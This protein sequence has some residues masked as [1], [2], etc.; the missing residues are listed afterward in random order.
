MGLPEGKRVCVIGAGIAGVS[1]AIR[2]KEKGYHVT[3]YEK[4][5]RI[6]GKCYTRELVVDG[7]HLTFEMGAA[8]VAI[9]YR[10]LLR[11][12]RMLKEET[13]TAMPYK[14]LQASGEIGSFRQRYWPKGKKLALLSQFIRCAFH[15]HRFYRK[16]VTKTGYKSNI[17]QEYLVPFWEYCQKHRMEDLVAWFELPLNAWGYGAPKTIPVWYVFGEIDFLGLFGLLITVTF[18]ESKFIKGLKNG[19][20]NLVEKLAVHEALN[21]ETSTDVL[22][23][24][25]QAG[26]VTIKT[27]KGEQQFDRLV[28]SS[29]KIGKLLSNPSVEESAFLRD[30]A[31]VPFATSL[32]TLNKPVAAKLLVVQNLRKINAVKIIVAPDKDSPLAVCYANIDEQKTE[33]EVSELFTRELGSLGYGPIEIHETCVWKDYFPHFSTYEGYKSLLAAQGKNRT[34]YVGV[35]NKFEFIEATVDSS[36]NLIDENFTGP[37]PSRW[38]FLSILRNAFFMLK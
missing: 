25:R 27:Q 14:V 24:D 6:G 9:N 38:E 18:G 28:I 26:G 4:R 37:T 5:D 35:I 17:P 23:I 7:K 11:Y 10:N 16:H 3:V 2:L 30:V 20:G 12:A 36:I 31:Y 32:C 8:V 34:T 29:P 21:I 13:C 19:Y 15:I 22:S 33:T 1:A